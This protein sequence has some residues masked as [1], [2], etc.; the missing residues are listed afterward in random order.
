MLRETK[1]NP[2]AEVQRHGRHAIELNLPLHVGIS[3]LV[4]IFDTEH[5]II[6]LYFPK[7]FAL[8]PHGRKNNTPSPKKLSIIP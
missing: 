4:D 8:W 2:Q 6:K 5:F 3:R 7:S 1:N